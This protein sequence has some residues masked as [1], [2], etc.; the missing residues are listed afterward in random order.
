MVVGLD[1]TVI[2]IPV[3]KRCIDIIRFVRANRF[4]LLLFHFGIYFRCPGN[5]RLLNGKAKTG[6]EK[7]GGA[8][9]VVIFFA[10]SEKN[11][12]CQKA[13]RFHISHFNRQLVVIDS[14]LFKGRLP[15]LV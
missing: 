2:G 13:Y 9:T 8:G 4:R 11:N 1:S 5:K 12:R 10:G 6:G 7:S 14:P 3:K 15:L